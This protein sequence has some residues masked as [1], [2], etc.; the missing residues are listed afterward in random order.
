MPPTCSSSAPADARLRGPDA[1]AW[2]ARLE[3]EQDNL[4]AALQWAL[5]GGRYADMAWLLLAVCWFWY[6]IGHWH[7]L[8]RWIAQLLPYRE[9]LAADLRLAILINLYAVCR[10]RRKNSSRSIAIIDEMMG[11]LEVCPDKLL[12][13]AVWHWIAAPFCRSCRGRRRL[14]RVDR[15]RP[16]RP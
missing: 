13:A 7:E 14:E 8:G 1:T 6:H 12:H 3:P 9:A 4:R 15:V 2:L 5:D 10:A 11:L 16:R